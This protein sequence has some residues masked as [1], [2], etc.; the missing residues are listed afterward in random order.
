MLYSALIGRP[1]DHSISPVL[2]NYLAK[3]SGL[4]YAH[5]KINIQS[6]NQLGVA[7]KNLRELGFCGINV[8]LPY[9]LA[10]MKHLNRLSPESA[11]IGAVNTIVFRNKQMIGYNTDAYGAI[12]A[13]EFKLKK[14]TPQDRVL[15]LG[16]G[17]AA[18]AIIYELYKKTKNVIILNRQTEEARIVSQ[19]LSRSKI[20]FNKLTDSNLR[21]YIA[22]SN[23]IINA[24][25]VGM[26]PRRN[27]RI[28]SQAVWSDI[29]VRNKYF[30]D[31][32]FNPYETEF[33]KSAGRLG[34]KTCSGTYMM[35]FQAL[36]A[37]HLWTGVNLSQVN[38]KVINN[39]LKKSLRN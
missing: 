38:V 12:S 5:L 9:K 26:F 35:I 23:I 24:T 20:L 6:E 33:L 30:F 3:R 4:E 31:A 8:T 14:I 32:I 37:F 1:V 16:A 17:G 7:L 18:R 15:V 22:I 34:A 19:D 21:K 29:K 28:V 27:D 11:K 13:I 10:I 39:I 36:R 2:F 25:P